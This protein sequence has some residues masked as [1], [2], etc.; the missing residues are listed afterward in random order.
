MNKY[1]KGI[2]L[3]FIYIYFFV[4][5]TVALYLSTNLILVDFFRANSST[6]DEF[7]TFIKQTIVFAGILSI[8]LILIIHLLW[9]KKRKVFY[10]VSILTLILSIVAIFI[11]IN[12][13]IGGP[14]R[15]KQEYSRYHQDGRSSI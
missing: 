13:D 10:V 4:F 3:T 6:A 14:V 8:I 9:R 5:Y 1:I 12:S 11:L 7:L 15:I 2:L